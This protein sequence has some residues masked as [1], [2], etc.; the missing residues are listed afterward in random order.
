[1]HA[2]VRVGKRS[3]VARLKEILKDGEDVEPSLLLRTLARLPFRLIITT[4]YDHLLEKAFELEGQPEP[5]VVT[6]PRAGFSPTA[7]RHLED[8]LD[9]VVPKELGP[10]R[11]GRDPEPAIVYKIHGTFSD[12][13]AGLVVSEDDYVQFLATMVQ[14]ASGGCRA[15][16]R[17]WSSTAASSSSDTGL[18][19]GISGRSTRL[20]SRASHATSG[21]CRMRYRGSPPRCGS[22]SGLKGVRIFDHDLVDLANDLRLK[23]QLDDV[24]A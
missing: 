19:T 16:F 15:S 3:L 18:R 23:F 4:N 20:S 8:R 22:T 10:R 5:M 7:K 13:A 6:Q 12:D 11:V 1:M 21:G 24:V 17:R 14:A 9:E 2:E